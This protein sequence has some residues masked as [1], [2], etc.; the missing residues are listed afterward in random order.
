MKE[1]RCEAA[2]RSADK[3]V[4]AVSGSL[5]SDRAKRRFGVG[6]DDIAYRIAQFNL[7][8]GDLS[9]LFYDLERARAR[10]FVDMLAGRPIANGR[11]TATGQRIQALDQQI[12]EQRFVATARDDSTHDEKLSAL[13]AKRAGL[14]EQLSQRDPDLA[15]AFRIEGASLVETSRALGP[16]EMLIYGLPARGKDPVRFLAVHRNGATS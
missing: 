4:D 14:V 11:G 2:Y 10:A 15:D 8:R 6:K 12:R 9:A 13:L 3:A 16:D 5:S 7:E 1:D